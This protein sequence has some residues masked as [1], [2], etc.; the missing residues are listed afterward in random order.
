MSSLSPCFLLSDCMLALKIQIFGPGS[1]SLAENS[2]VLQNFI[3]AQLRRDNQQ[4]QVKLQ[5]HMMIPPESTSERE[6]HTSS[7]STQ[8]GRNRV[9]P[10]H[11]SL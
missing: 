2:S 4:M 9:M 3:F 10:E 11:S 8:V 5:H 6:E 7:S 1:S